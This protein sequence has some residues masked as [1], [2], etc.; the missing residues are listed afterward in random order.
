MINSFDGEY[1]FLSNFHDSPIQEG[2]VTYPTV[3]HYFQAQKTLDM[4]Q[5]LMIARAATP[6]EAKKMGRQVTLRADWED[7]KLDVM[8]KGLR[9][10]FAIPE[11]RNKLLATGSEELVEGNWWGD[12]CW[13]VCKGVGENNLGKLLMKIR[14]ELQNLG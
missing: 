10:K 5:R 8:E 14:S 3:E 12:T 13:G 2:I 4:E 6:G 11:L 1:R 9:M 7:V